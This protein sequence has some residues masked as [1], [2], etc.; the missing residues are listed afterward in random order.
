LLL[1]GL[2]N[3]YQVGLH[4]ELV[5][6]RAL[7]RARFGMIPHLLIG[8]EFWRIGWQERQENVAFLL[9]DEALGFLAV[10]I[11]RVI[12]DDQDGV[13]GVF[14][15]LFQERDESLGAHPFLDE[16]ASHVPAR[17]NRT[18]DMKTEAPAASWRMI[19][20]STTSFRF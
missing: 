5:E 11:A 4:I 18:D 14:V 7:S 9:L 17:G 2:Q 15:Q 12:G 1:N 10:V 13:A 16:T 20:G 19:I 3:G 6:N 8:I